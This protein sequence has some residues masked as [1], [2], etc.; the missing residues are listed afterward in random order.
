M[1]SNECANFRMTAIPDGVSSSQKAKTGKDV[2]RCTIRS[3]HVN[4]FVVHYPRAANCNCRIGMSVYGSTKTRLA[5][6][7]QSDEIETRLIIIITIIKKKTSIPRR[8][9]DRD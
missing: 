3:G 8:S 5:F 9:N 2:Y 1:L 7:T 6:T 4:D